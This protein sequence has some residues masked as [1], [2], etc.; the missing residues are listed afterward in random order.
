MISTFLSDYQP[1][2]PRQNERAIVEQGTLEAPSAVSVLVNAL[3]T[4]S[5]ICRQGDQQRL[6]RY[7]AIQ[8][9][10]AKLEEELQGHDCEAMVKKHIAALNEAG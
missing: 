10:I 1:D 8:S 7:N 5:F 4:R 9:E 2:L 6:A 3:L